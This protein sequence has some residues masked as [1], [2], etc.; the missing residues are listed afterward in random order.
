MKNKT[1][2]VLPQVL[3][4]LPLCWIQIIIFKKIE[5]LIR[6]RVHQSK[7]SSIYKTKNEEQKREKS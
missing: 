1:K 6:S 7:T 3:D 2:N 5:E 4:Q